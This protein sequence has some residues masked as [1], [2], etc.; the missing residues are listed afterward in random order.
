VADVLEAILGAAYLSGGRDSALRATKALSVLPPTDSRGLTNHSE[1]A[2]ASWED[3]DRRYRYIESQVT[4][5]Y[6]TISAVESMIG[7][8]Y[9][10]GPRAYLL[11][12]AL[13][14]LVR[15][16]MCVSLS[17]LQ[18]HSSSPAIHDGDSYERLEFLG[19]AILD[20]S[21]FHSRD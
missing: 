13:V 12:E 11:Q 16:W 20:F 3:F 18:T 10:F 14:S 19:D 7:T 15:I 21:E 8:D 9:K 2:F 6:S 4:I 5:P 1:T 17:L